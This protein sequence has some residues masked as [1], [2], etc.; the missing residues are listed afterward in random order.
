MSNRIYL[1]NTYQ[2]III[3]VVINFVFSVTIF[4]QTENSTR[5]KIPHSDSLEKYNLL[6]IQPDFQNNFQGSLN[7]RRKI[8]FSDNLY[9]TQFFKN[10]NPFNSISFSQKKSI[11]DLPGLGAYQH[12]TNHIS[13]NSNKFTLDLGI[14]LTN[15][16]TVLME[17]PLYQFSF[18]TS[19]NYSVTDWLDAYLYG[20]YLSNPINR[21]K[22]F[23]D[24]FMYDNALFIQSE[25]GGGLKTNFKKVNAD[26]KIFSIYRKESKTLSPV[27]SVIRIEF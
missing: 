26:L 18:H 4:A 16:H 7:E 24:P 19:F 20:R 23:F 3:V 25:I 11:S 13:L 2:N 15:Q 17:A 27:N 6:H 14:G 22:G 10:K 8:K 9:G 12:F 21:P 1:R 5:L